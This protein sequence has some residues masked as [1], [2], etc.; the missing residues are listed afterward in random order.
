MKKIL[1]LIIIAIAVL[2]GIALADKIS[3][4]RFTI[5]P[6][7]EPVRVEIELIGWREVTGYSSTIDQCDDTPFITASGETVRKGIIACP[8]YIPFGTK[9]LIDG[10]VYTCGDRMHPDYVHR[11]DIWFPDR[12]SAIEFGKQILEVKKVTIY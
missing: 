3:S 2:V 7:E 6:S 11:F 5:T 1:Y 9:V 4:R 8:R 10:K 12:E